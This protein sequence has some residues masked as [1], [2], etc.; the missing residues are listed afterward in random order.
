MRLIQS[1][2]YLAQATEENGISDHFTDHLDFSPFM[3]FKGFHLTRVQLQTVPFVLIRL[4]RLEFLTFEA[5]DSDEQTDARTTEQSKHDLKW[6]QELTTDD[7]T[8]H[9]DAYFECTHL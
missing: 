7:V 1:E 3:P 5:L 9:G 2:V 4:R 8:C 6:E